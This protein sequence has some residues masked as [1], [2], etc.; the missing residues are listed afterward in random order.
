MRLSTAY[1]WGP[2]AWGIPQKG[3]TKVDRNVIGSGDLV[4]ACSNKTNLSTGP[5][6][7]QLLQK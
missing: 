3:H 1:L 4:G 7:S 6:S 5:V 2:V